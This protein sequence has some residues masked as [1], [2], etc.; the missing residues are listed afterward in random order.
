[1]F[2]PKQNNTH[3]PLLAKSVFATIIFALIICFTAFFAS[4]FCASTPLSS[5]FGEH[6][7]TS[8]VNTTSTNTAYASNSNDGSSDSAAPT[9]AA[10]AS[11]APANASSDSAAPTDAASASAA[12]TDAAQNTIATVSSSTNNASSGFP[13]FSFNQN[14]IQSSFSKLGKDYIC[15]GYDV[16]VEDGQKT[17]C[18]LIAAAKNITLGSAQIAGDAILAADCINTQATNISNN[19]FAAANSANINATVTNEASII[20]KEVNLSGSQRWVHVWA[21]TVVLSGNFSNVDVF[22]AHVIVKSDAIITGKLSVKS[23]NDPQI[24]SGARVTSVD[25]EKGTDTITSNMSTEIALIISLLFTLLGTF[26][27]GLLL[28]A[29]FRTRPFDLCAQRFCKSPARVLLTGLLTCILVPII[30][31]ILLILLVGI[32][33][34]LILVAFAFC[35]G[36]L[37]LPFTALALSRKIFNKLN[38]WIGAILMLV[39]VG[40]LACVPYLGIAIDAFCTL[41]TVGSIVVCFFDWKKS[42]KQA[43]NKQTE[44]NSAQHPSSNSD[45]FGEHPNALQAPNFDEHHAASQAHIV[46]KHHAASQ[47]GEPQAGAQQADLQPDNM[48]QAGAQ[49]NKPTDDTLSTIAMA[50]A[51]GDSAMLD[52]NVSRT[53]EASNNLPDEKRTD[54]KDALSTTKDTAAND[55]TDSATNESKNAIASAAENSASTN[56]N[57]NPIDFA[58]IAAISQDLEDSAAKKANSTAKRADSVL[59]KIASQSAA[60]ED[61]AA[62]KTKGHDSTQNSHAQVT[63]EDLSQAEAILAELARKATLAQ[64]QSQAQSQAQVQENESAHFQE[65]EQHHEQTEKQPTRRNIPKLDRDAQV[66]AILARLQ[67]KQGDEE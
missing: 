51:Q 62:K 12:P 7:T 13:L 54:I 25:Y 17:E 61:S 59:S 20:A 48:R 50:L 27:C 33:T 30:A 44:T 39:I 60:Q 66:K 53:Y 11:A 9:D 24:E 64:S 31:C 45:N 14:G 4:A 34:M 38:K 40:V 43:E 35:L 42:V 55:A 21:D 67:E 29:F 10:S 16:E 19:L 46:D 6:H 36:L 22:A 49:P 47:A 32:K 57:A 1:M 3:A 41:F 23:S 28:L 5:F 2:K 65:E 26:V 58:K 63:Q 52:G 15:A 18:N 56:K 37:S 8:S